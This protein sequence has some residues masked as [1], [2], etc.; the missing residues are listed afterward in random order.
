MRNKSG[1][2]KD[3]RAKMK[4]MLIKKALAFLININSSS[5]NYANVIAR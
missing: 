4:E 5:H 3:E 1:K 2:W